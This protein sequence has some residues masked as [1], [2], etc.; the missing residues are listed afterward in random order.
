MATLLWPRSLVSEHYQKAEYYPT[1]CTTH[2]GQEKPG[3]SSSAPTGC[4]F[5]LIATERELEPALISW[6]KTAHRYI[7]LW[8]GAAEKNRSQRF[9]LITGPPT[10]GKRHSAKMRCELGYLRFVSVSYSFS[11]YC[12]WITAFAATGA[13]IYTVSQSTNKHVHWPFIMQDS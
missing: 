11:I 8:P 12:N 7:Y 3:C 5:G 6:S 2:G 1:Q 10:N 9:V 4:Y 13:R